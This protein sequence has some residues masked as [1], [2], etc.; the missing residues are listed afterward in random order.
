MKKK[1]TE[2]LRMRSDVGNNCRFTLYL[3]TT[4]C[5]I[6]KCLFYRATAALGQKVLFKDTTVAQICEK[7]GKIHFCLYF[8]HFGGVM[9]VKFRTEG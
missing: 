1:R 6:S 2:C 3:L 9:A 5:R 8:T 7:S 4:I